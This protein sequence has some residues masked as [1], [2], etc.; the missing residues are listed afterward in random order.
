[1]QKETE[2]N[3]KALIGQN[4]AIVNSASDYDNVNKKI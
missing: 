4:V 1:M 3:L 2:K